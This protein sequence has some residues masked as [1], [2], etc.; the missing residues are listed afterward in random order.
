[1][2][3]F[4]YHL[5]N[6]QTSKDG[7]YTKASKLQMT[8]IFGHLNYFWVTEVAQRYQKQDRNFPL[9]GC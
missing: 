4:S 6:L 3:S 8:S 1:M 7:F 5:T 2:V 9:L